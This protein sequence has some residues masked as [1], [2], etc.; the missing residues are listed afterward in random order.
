VEDEDPTL[1]GAVS[2]NR[3][4]K[5]E[6]GLDIHDWML[7]SLWESVYPNSVSSPAAPVQ[8]HHWFPP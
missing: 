8:A 5:E 1:A 4:V 2:G 6:A 3:E 7:E